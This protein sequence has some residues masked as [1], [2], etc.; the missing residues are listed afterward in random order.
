MSA[1]GGKADM[2]FAARMSASDPKRTWQ[3]VQFPRLNI[4]VGPSSVLA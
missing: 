1:F 2:P 3:A 4:Q